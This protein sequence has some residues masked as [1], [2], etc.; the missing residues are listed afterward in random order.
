MLTVVQGTYY[1][2]T[3]WV[4]SNWDRMLVAHDTNDPHILDTNVGYY[5]G[6]FNVQISSLDGFITN[7]PMTYPISMEDDTGYI[8]TE[9][10]STSATAWKPPNDDDNRLAAHNL[11]VLRGALQENASNLLANG[12]YFNPTLQVVSINGITTPNTYLYYAG[13]NDDVTE[14]IDRHSLEIISIVNLK[15][16]LGVNDNDNITAVISY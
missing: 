13:S 3:G 4:A 15:S 2:R 16:F 9:S 12:N 14:P 10:G 1:H 7:E 6:T 11:G 8:L 5:H